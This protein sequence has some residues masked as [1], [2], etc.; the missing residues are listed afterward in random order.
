MKGTN[1]VNKNSYEGT[2]NR[3]E[4]NNRPRFVSL[5]RIRD[6]IKGINKVGKNHYEKKEIRIDVCGKG[7]N[8][9]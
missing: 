4:K 5:K 3:F 7:G 9:G 2:I 6:V 8:V 1:F